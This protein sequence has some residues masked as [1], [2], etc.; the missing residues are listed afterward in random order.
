MTQLCP[1]SY[2]VQYKIFP[3]AQNFILTGTDLVDFPEVMNVHMLFEAYD[4]I[5]NPITTG[6]GLVLAKIRDYC[7]IKVSNPFNCKR[8]TGRTNPHYNEGKNLLN[9]K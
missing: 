1:R 6:K 4:K 3:F 8:L 9:S 7:E 5:N 2:Q